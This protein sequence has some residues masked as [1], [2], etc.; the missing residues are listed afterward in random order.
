MPS[1][2]VLVLQWNT[3]TNCKSWFKINGLY[4]K[5]NGL[6]SKVLDK[7]LLHETHEKKNNPLQLQKFDYHFPQSIPDCLHM[8]VNI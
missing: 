7:E 5:I 1:K 8:I 6:Y 3:D 2:G 4:C